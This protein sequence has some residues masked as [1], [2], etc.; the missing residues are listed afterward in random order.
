MIGHSVVL[1]S[2]NIVRLNDLSWGVFDPDFS[3]VEVLQYEVDPRECLQQTDLLLHEQVGTLP[4]ESLV[5]LLLYLDHNITSLEARHLIC[6]PVE[7]VL[8]AIW[9]T[10]VNLSLQDLLLFDNFLAIAG[11]ALV[12]LVDLLALSIAVVA[13]SLSL[14][15]HS[16]SNH[17]HG[18]FNA[19]ASAA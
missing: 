14:G 13:R 15:V 2:L 1:H 11:L 12:L 18:D 16:R 6:F 5:G 8:F 4:L 17:L 10:L 7:N 9:C 19:P 3:A